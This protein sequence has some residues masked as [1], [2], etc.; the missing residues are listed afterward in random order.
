M[1]WHATPVVRDNGE[2]MLRTFNNGTLFGTVASDRAPALLALHGWGRDRSDLSPSLVGREFVALDLP[3]FG[4][5]PAPT[6]TW[7]AADY[8]EAVAVAVRELDAG[9]LLVVAHS[10]GG[11]VAAHL[12]AD[13]PEAASGVVFM[14]VPLLRQVTTIKSPLPYRAVRLGAR[15]GVVSDR[16]LAAMRSKYGSADYNAT[17]GVMRDVFVR[18]VNED[19]R[20]QLSRITCPV[21]FCWGSND[22]AAPPSI[23][24]EAAGI[25]EHCVA[26]EIVENAGHDV[27][28]DAPGVLSSAIDAVAAA[29]ATE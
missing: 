6:V 9:P 3:G 7:G 15:L 1:G 5:S 26:L 10:F 28:R 24:R 13:H 21:A 16:K 18:V 12:A 20:N 19:Y 4:A 22:T 25:V 8:A 2:V 29:S 14:G 11:R 27:H 23:A 17:T